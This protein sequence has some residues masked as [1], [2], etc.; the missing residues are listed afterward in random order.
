MTST[1][2]PL[3]STFLLLEFHLD[4]E[5]GLEGRAAVA[6]GGVRLVAADADQ[7]D[8][9]IAHG[10]FEEPHERVAQVARRDVAQEDGVVTLHL[11]EGAGE[12]ADIGQPGV[13]LR[14]LERRHQR[15][16]LG[17]IRRDHEHA[18]I[19][20]HAGEIAGPVVLG[21][22]VPGNVEL[23]VVGVEPGLVE[24]LRKGEEVLAGG[25]L[26]RLLAQEPVVLEQSQRRGPVG[27]RLHE[28]A[29]LEGLS[30][31]EAGGHAELLDGDVAAPRHAQRHD[32]H[33]DAEAARLPRR[34]P[35]RRRRSRCRRRARTSRFWPV[36]GKAAVPNRMALARSLRSVPTTAWIFCTS[37]WLLG[38]ISMAAPLPK[39]T[40]PPR[41]TVFLSS[42]TRLTYSRA[43]SCWSDGHAVRAVEQEE[44]V[45]AL[46]AV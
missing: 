45:H 8:A 43:C 18:G 19:A 39:T 13:Q 5:D 1:T 3:G 14:G 25:E 29:H 40:T 41:S 9:E 36:S 24:R 38:V 20:L 35:G 33:G 28:D 16:V 44:D 2:A 4:R 42:E 7:A 22:L 15:A 12:A 21:D 26:D 34:H 32:I 37:T 46:D 27:V 17:G 23:H 30:L 10:A 6:A 11:G 31:L